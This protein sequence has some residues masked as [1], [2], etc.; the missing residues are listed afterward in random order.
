MDVDGRNEYGEK[1]VMF[2]ILCTSC[3]ISLGDKMKKE[4]IGVA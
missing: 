2:S 3:H 4:E 1:C